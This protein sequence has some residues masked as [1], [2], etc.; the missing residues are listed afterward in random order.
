MLVYAEN[1]LH[2]QNFWLASVYNK[3]CRLVTYSELKANFFGIHTYYL[4]ITITYYI[5][6]TLM[7]VIFVIHWHT[8]VL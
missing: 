4:L 7:F 2:V 8:S 1:C 5:L 3:L 6:I